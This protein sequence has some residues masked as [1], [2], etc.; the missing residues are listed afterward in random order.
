MTDLHSYPPLSPGIDVELNL[1]HY[2][3][4]VSDDLTVAVLHKVIADHERIRIQEYWEDVLL[5]PSK[6]GTRLEGLNTRKGG[7]G[8]PVALHFLSSALQRQASTTLRGTELSQQLW[9]MSLDDQRRFVL[10]LAPPA[11]EGLKG[12]LRDSSALFAPDFHAM[13]LTFATPRPFVEHLV[14]SLRANSTPLYHA[15]RYF[16]LLVLL[17]S[18]NFMLFPMDL[19]NWTFRSKWSVL[20]NERYSRQKASLVT[21]V[22]YLLKGS[23]N[24]DV[25]GWS[26]VVLTSSTLVTAKDLSLALISGVE[27][28]LL[29]LVDASGAEERVLDSLR[30][31][32]SRVGQT[33]RLLFNQA[34]PSNAVMQTRL[35]R[36]YPKKGLVRHDGKFLWLTHTRPALAEWAD[37]MRKYI[38]QLTTARIAGQIAKLIYF[39]D[40]LL[41]LDEPPATPLAVSRVKHI[42]DATLRNSLTYSEYLRSR[43][44]NKTTATA[45]LSLLRSFFDWYADYLLASGIQESATFRNPVL[46]SD[47]LGRGSDGG[48]Q[49]PRNALPG[50]ILE[51]LKTLLIE[52]DFA[53]GKASK[54]QYVLVNDSLQG[55][56]KRVW[57]P[58][59]TI[60]LYLLLEAP[61]RSHQARWLD[62][63]ELDELRYNV[64]SHSLIR[65]DY[66]HADRK[67]VV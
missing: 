33:F 67:S 43:I 64:D 34:Y 14:E 7:D 39:A 52:N 24:S 20:R 35:P 44:D 59:L 60:C 55:K 3:P 30:S 37:L 1:A 56:P 18:A 27:V 65:N 15:Q 45:A 49:T 58:A 57:F 53:F 19:R 63:G 51:E 9:S 54:F 10:A 66:P 4:H 31:F 25:Q 62:S 2:Q 29:E 61:L 12:L 47:S 38:A 28:R 42:F 5:V 8:H 23:R 48:G 22:T 46:H 6:A 32:V 17:W 11:R 13:A 40:F 41:T 21:Q 26:Y 36:K 16:E 50:Y